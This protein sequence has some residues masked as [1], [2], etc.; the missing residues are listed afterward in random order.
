[1][2]TNSCSIFDGKAGAAFHLVCYSWALE[3]EVCVPLNDHNHVS[4][5]IVIIFGGW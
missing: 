3:A 4:V 1:M 5:D 2:E